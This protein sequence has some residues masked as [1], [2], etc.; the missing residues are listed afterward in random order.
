MLC[1][2]LKPWYS[3]NRLAHITLW[4]SSSTPTISDSVELREF[5]RCLRESDTSAPLPMVNTAPVWLFMSMCT[6]NAASMYHDS[7][8]LSSAS[9]CRT[10]SMVPFRNHNV[11]NSFL[12]S[13]SFGSVTRDD[14]N[15]TT[16]FT[17]GLALLHRNIA[18]ITKV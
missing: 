15:P 16:G 6:A 4:I 1:F 13:P 9:N 11:F 12:Q 3:M 17:S 18:F 14:R 7:V 2:T 10:S 5:T 8:C